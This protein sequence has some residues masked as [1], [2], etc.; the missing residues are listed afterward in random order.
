MDWGYFLKDK[1]SFISQYIFVIL[2]IYVLIILGRSVYKNYQT[3]QKIVKMENEIRHLEEEKNYLENII[4]YYQSDSFKELEARRKLNLQKPG[5]KVMAVESQSI[6]ESGNLEDIYS[7]T[8]QSEEANAVSQ[9]ES[10]FD[11]WREFLLGN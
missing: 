5:E 1:F 6:S 11:R 3:N 9:S 10:N 8:L 2:L 4:V 7:K